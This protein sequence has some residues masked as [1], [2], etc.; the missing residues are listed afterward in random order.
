[1]SG[2]R[3]YLGRISAAMLGIR[4]KDAEAAGIAQAGLPDAPSGRMRWSQHSVVR[5][6][7]TV[8]GVIYLGWVW[9]FLLVTGSHVD[10]AAYWRGAAG[11]PYA[12]SH[13]GGEGAFL[14]SP[15]ASQVLAPF[16]AWPMAVLTGA[17]LALSLAAAAYLVGARLAALAL[18]TPLPFVWQDLGS[19]NIHVLVAAAVV[20]GFRFPATWSF[21]LLTKLTPGVALLWFVAR[22]EWRSLGVALGTTGALV[23]ISF[24]LAPGLWGQ[25]LDVL[26]A[27]AASTPGG[28][29]IPVPLPMRLA[30]A[31]GVVWWG[32]R[33]NR[34]WTVPLA[35]MLALP[36][37]WIYDGFAVLLGVV[38]LLRRPRRAEARPARLPAA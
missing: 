21:V 20:L 15:A 11:D 24:A 16:A 22:R 5:D 30:L 38:S 36:A 4:R 2:G 12:L 19:G 13:V 7:L 1:M 9:H 14:Y 23:A 29:F 37:I 31:A 32:A 26:R 8:A 35:A 34:A 27:N 6:A 10:V 18:L 33:T 25:W 28:I 3:R 17:L